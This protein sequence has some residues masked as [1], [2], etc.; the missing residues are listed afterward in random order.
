MTSYTYNAAGLVASMAEP[1]GTTTYVYDAENQLTSE[2]SPAGTTTYTY[3]ALGRIAT[4]TAPTGVT[5]CRDKRRRSP[6]DSYQPC[7]GDHHRL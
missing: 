6:S 4:V 2:T 1:Q 5:G 7:R 3:G